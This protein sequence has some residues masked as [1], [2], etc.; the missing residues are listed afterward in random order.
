VASAPL[1]HQERGL[2][3][4]HLGTKPG[5]RSVRARIRLAQEP[6]AGSAGLVRAIAAGLTMHVAGPTRLVVVRTMLAVG[7]PTGVQ[8]RVLANRIGARAETVTDR[9]RAIAPTVG[10]G[11]PARGHGLG[12]LARH[13]VV[14]RPRVDRPARGR[15]VRGRT[16]RG[17]IVLAMVGRTLGARARTAPSPA[18]GARNAPMRESLVRN[19]SSLATRARTGTQGRTVDHG[20]REDRRHRVDRALKVVPGIAPDRGDH[21]RRGPGRVPGGHPSNAS[22]PLRRGLRLR[23]SSV[24]TR[25]SSPADDRSRRPSPRIAR[26]SACSSSRSVAPRWTSSCSTPR[27]CA[28]PSSRSREGR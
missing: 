20:R 25:R 5:A 23:S 16:D 17:R 18:G 4:S 8:T 11:P 21:G 10:T 12:Q 7:A 24:P 6:R 14:G 15:M 27:R 2:A 28:S 19:A 13:I 3:A 26:R 9:A 22:G 1:G